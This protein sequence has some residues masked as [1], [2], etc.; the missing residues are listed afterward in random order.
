ML[1]HKIG[2]LL[3]EDMTVTLNNF[4]LS[5]QRAVQSIHEQVARLKQHKTMLQM[6]NMQ[7]ED[8][9]RTMKQIRGLNL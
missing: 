5:Q 6:R 9:N 4:V 2:A 3:F 1:T 7:L 8:E